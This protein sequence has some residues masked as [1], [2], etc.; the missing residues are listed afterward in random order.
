MPGIG[1]RQPTSGV[2]S[3]LPRFPGLKNRVDFL[4]SEKG[5]M[6]TQFHEVANI[7]PLL[8]G[9]ELQALVEDIRQNDRYGP[10]DLTIYKALVQPR[11]GL[12]WWE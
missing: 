12:F 1:S 10:G 7:F 8:E 6:D 5:L 11:P 4:F 3:I 9:E 2:L